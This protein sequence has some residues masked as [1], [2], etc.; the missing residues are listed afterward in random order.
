MIRKKFY[1]AS[2]LLVMAVSVAVTYL[3]T[4]NSM[5]AYSKPSAYKNDSTNFAS[6]HQE[7]RES[8]VIMVRQRN[9]NFIRPL[10]LAEA[11]YQ[12][13]RLQPLKNILKER[14]ASYKANGTLLRGTVYLKNLES[15]EWIEVGG[16]QEYHPGS[17]MKVGVMMTW[18]AMMEKDPSLENKKLRITSHLPYEQT[19]LTAA[20]LQLN[21]DYSIKELMK[22]MIVDS[23]ND[24]TVLLIENI[25]RKLH[26]QVWNITN[27]KAPS[28]DDLNNKANAID[29]AK[30]FR[31]LYNSTFLS[32]PSSEFALGLLSASNFKAGMVKLLPEGVQ[33]AHKFGER[34]SE[35]GQQFHEGG[36]VYLNNT[37][38]VI[39]I[40][41]EGKD[42][43]A[44][45]NVIATLSQ[46]C[47]NF[48]RKLK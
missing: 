11:Q 44:L 24:A 42:K 30:L 6:I 32:N 16:E 28:L 45:P 36:I 46:D 7:T 5:K 34:F 37:P 22:A 27:S 33:V 14:I 9:F 47:Y 43:A 1:I 39:M 21:K 26:E 25:D 38:Y 23:D 8:D 17:M 13:E 15:T 20:P 3:F 10:I 4:I 41:T 48:M 18:L 19:T 12:G 31:V 35:A 29:F 2:L 40:M